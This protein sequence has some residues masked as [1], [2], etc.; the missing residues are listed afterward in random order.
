MLDIETIKAIALHKFGDLSLERDY[1]SN[2]FDSLHKTISTGH[3]DPKI[4]R[5]VLLVYNEYLKN[6]T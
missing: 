5:Y 3:P 4:W 6:E 1:F 2:S